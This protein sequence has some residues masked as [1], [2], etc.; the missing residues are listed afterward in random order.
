M[1]HFK[2]KIDDHVSKDNF[3]LSLSKLVLIFDFFNSSKKEPSSLSEVAVM[4]FASC[5][6]LLKALFFYMPLSK[7]Q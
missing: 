6:Y 4:L 5:Q 7:I 2:F 3:M 1:P